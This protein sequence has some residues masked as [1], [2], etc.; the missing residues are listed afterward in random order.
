MIPCLLLLGSLT[1]H[2]L[3]LTAPPLDPSV[4][5]TIVITTRL[6]FSLAI[7]AFQVYYY[8]LFSNDFLADSATIKTFFLEY[9]REYHTA[10]CHAFINFPCP[11]GVHCIHQFS[12]SGFLTCEGE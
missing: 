3:W 8:T 10:L 2:T 6:K 7:R 11:P 4:G 1:F 9:G 5:N 12:Y